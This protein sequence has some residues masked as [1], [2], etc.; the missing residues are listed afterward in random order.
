MAKQSN[1]ETVLDKRGENKIFLQEW[2]KV[3]KKIKKLVRNPLKRRN[4]ID[5][6]VLDEL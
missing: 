4:L 1:S 2:E 6:L 3:N 5:F